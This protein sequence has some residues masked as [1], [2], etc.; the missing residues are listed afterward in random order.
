MWTSGVNDLRGAAVTGAWSE[1]VDRE[2]KS[3][4]VKPKIS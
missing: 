1:T 2:D 3:A 4:I